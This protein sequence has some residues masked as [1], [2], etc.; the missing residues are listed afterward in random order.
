MARG[1][2]GRQSRAS[3][4]SRVANAPTLTPFSALST[5]L[6]PAPLLE[7]EDGRQWHPDPDRGALS[8]GGRYARVVV[9]KRPL[10]AYSRP[11]YA[12]RGLPAGFQVPVG[13]MFE[14]PFRVITCLRRKI[15]REIIFARNKAG[16]GVRR[17]RP[18]PR[19]WKS[20]VSC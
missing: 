8:V 9:H 18:R 7:L 20:N 19:D 15:R 16:S 14:S 11:I 12:K 2:A 13:T 10:V 17:R 3:D 4:A 6:G 1:R 5:L